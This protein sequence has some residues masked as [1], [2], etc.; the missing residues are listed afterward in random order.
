MKGLL[1]CLSVVVVLLAAGGCSVPSPQV[2]DPPRAAAEATPTSTPVPPTRTPTLAPPTPT[3]SPE[4]ATATLPAED[5]PAAVLADVISVE[6][7][8]EPGAY[9]FA[10]GIRSP[11]TGCGQYADWW[12]VVGEE[13]DLLYRRVLLHSHV[14]EQPF[15]R[16]GGPID[17]EADTVVWVRAHMNTG[18]YG[19]AAFRG[20]VGEGFRE[21]VLDAAFAAGL[22]G[23]P[24]LPDG[25][26]F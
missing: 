7:S 21:A 12:E 22:E 14:N 24:P 17:M 20:S 6:A 3:L 11:D 9:R 10:V 2:E 26:A 23:E 5:V 18:G 1:L 8:G 15:V 4:P 19:G 16:S 13:G 25:C